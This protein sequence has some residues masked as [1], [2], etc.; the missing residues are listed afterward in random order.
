MVYYE[1]VLLFHRTEK[2]VL[3]SHEQYLD[4]CLL[5]CKIHKDQREYGTDMGM[6]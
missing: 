2:D 3:V 1:G 5:N 4:A 6:F